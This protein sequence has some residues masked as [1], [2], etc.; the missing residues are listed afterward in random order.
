MATENTVLRSNPRSKIIINRLQAYSPGLPSTSEDESP[1]LATVVPFVVNAKR[2]PQTTKRSRAKRSRKVTIEEAF[3]FYF[4]PE[5]ADLNRFHEER[6]VRAVAYLLS[7]G[8]GG[9]NDPID[10]VA[11]NGLAKILECCADRIR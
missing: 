10:G 4:D 3:S 6:A 9:G 1:K 2:E 5:D 8:S 7:W 11:A